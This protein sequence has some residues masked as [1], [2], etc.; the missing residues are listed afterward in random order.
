[1]SLTLP[2]TVIP[3]WEIRED[4]KVLHKLAEVVEFLTCMQEVCG[5][6]LIWETNSPDQGF[7]GFNQSLQADAKVVLEI[8]PCL[9]LSIFLTMQSLNILP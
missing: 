4:F 8:N 5:S 2:F 7:L 3:L 6:N 9:H 1:M